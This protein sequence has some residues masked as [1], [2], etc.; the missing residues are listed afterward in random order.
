M[1]NGQSTRS[2]HAKIYPGDICVSSV[3]YPAV[4]RWRVV[5]LVCAHISILVGLTLIASTAFAQQSYAAPS[6]T[7]GVDFNFQGMIDDIGNKLM[8]ILASIA[9]LFW[10]IVTPIITI[11]L[12]IKVISMVRKA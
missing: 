9:P 4:H 11:M 3:S 5:R 6:P 7:G 10:K 1:K 8:L 12:V 2:D